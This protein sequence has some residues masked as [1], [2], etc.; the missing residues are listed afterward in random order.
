M[1]EEEAIRLWYSGSEVQTPLDGTEARGFYGTFA[2][3][4]AGSLTDKYVIANGKLRR[5][6]TGATLGANRAY[7]DLQDV[8]TTPLVI[9]DPA[10]A[11]VRRR[12]GV[13]GN[14]GAATDLENVFQLNAEGTQK[15]I[16]NGQLYILR[17]GQVVK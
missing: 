6:G 8:P 13:G 11:P 2:D 3:M 16:L 4:P 17:D 14:N 10:N 9:N 12:L 5:C 7:L 1:A 15:L